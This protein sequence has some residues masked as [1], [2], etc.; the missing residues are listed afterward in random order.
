MTMLRGGMM[1]LIYEKMMA[2][3]LGGI[4]ESSAMSIM[5]A[6]V[7]IIAETLHLWICDAWANVIQLGLAV[8]LLANQL[9]AVCIAPIIIA[10][11]KLR[12]VR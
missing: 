1:S 7:E 9:G 11:S 4:N 3:P 5:G 2:L 12:P 10:A 6:D 8:W